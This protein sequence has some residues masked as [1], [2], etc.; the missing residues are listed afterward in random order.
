M[1]LFNI[2]DYKYNGKIIIWV[3]SR[4]HQH[5][6]YTHDPFTVQKN[7][8]TLNLCLSFCQLNYLASV[9]T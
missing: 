1:M 9:V 2:S 6:V 8:V 7:I 4:I 5:S 3:Q